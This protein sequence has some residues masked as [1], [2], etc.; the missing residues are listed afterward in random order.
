MYVPRTHYLPIRFIMHG[1]HA[2]SFVNDIRIHIDGARRKHACTLV[3]ARFF[4]QTRP[5]EPTEGL[6]AV[7]KA[8]RFIG[9][10]NPRVANGV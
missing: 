7:R 8:V 2:R 9:F 1:C 10:S 5:V 3:T 6:N 4:P